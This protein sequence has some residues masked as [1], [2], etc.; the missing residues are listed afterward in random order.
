MAHSK[1][2]ERK[3]G[4]KLTVVDK[5]Q[6]WFSDFME[7]MQKKI[8]EPQLKIIFKFP[9][10]GFVVPI[11][12]L[13]ISFSLINGGLLKTT[14]FPVIEGD[15][16]T[17]N[18]K[19]PAGTPEKQ[20]MKW[21]NHVEDAAWRVNERMKARRPDG[22]DLINVV[23]KNQAGN[24]YEGNILI[25]LLDS[26][27]RQEYPPQKSSL[28]IADS[29][30][31]EAGT[32]LGAEEVSYT[33][34]SPFG[35][36][37]SV[38]LFSNDLS[39]L[40]T[41]VEVLKDSLNE[42]SDL[43]N[44]VDNN[45][46]G[47]R[48]LNITLK[49]K[50]RMLGLDLQTVV[51]QVRQGFFGAEVQRLQRGEDEVRIWVRYN[52][53]DRESVGDL[54]DMRIRTT[55]GSA[56]P[57]QEIANIAPTRGVIS[58]RHLDGKREIRVEADAASAD[59]ST[60]DVL[61]EIETQLLPRILANYPSVNFSM[62][63]QV[64]DNAKTGASISR[65]GPIALFLLVIIIVLT[66]RSWSQTLAVLSI[67]PFGLIGVLFGHWILGRP[68]SFILSGLGVL[69]LVGIMVNDALVLV[70]QFN[71]TIKAGKPF[72]EALYEAAVSRFRPIFLTSVTTIAGLLP[73]IAEKSL[74]AQFLIPM[75]ITIAFGLAVATLLVLV[76]LPSMMLMMNWYKRKFVLL[77]Q[78]EEPDATIIEPAFEGRKDYFMI[79]FL[80]SLGVLAI[81]ALLALPGMLM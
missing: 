22:K 65:V 24:T 64:R 13:M 1:A 54:E 36:A 79:W 29:I 71:N 46:T 16:I 25:N 37:V 10:M 39:Q 26:E 32:I 60:R 67:I 52:E 53:S 20:T 19:M 66:F 31:A 8:Y 12:L 63:G 42:F 7:W 45:Q 6:K 4:K 43:R 27:T 61:T 40:E 81:L 69:A 59:V 28:S 62:E 21:L 49:E 33:L 3:E 55:D 14:I 48:E 30:K 57:L 70:S 34:A 73:L 38:A 11:A 18:I 76:T 74:Q 75:A 50:A 68:F 44:V 56:Y 77:F 23:S 72:K 5:V 47:L 2:L 78:G 51:G 41:A 9:I 17:T 15:Y 58:I 35:K 80:G